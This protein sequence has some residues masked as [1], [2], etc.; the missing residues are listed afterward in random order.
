M[1]DWQSANQE[2]ENVRPENHAHPSVL[3]L[4]WRIYAISGRWAVAVTLATA[5]MKA[6]PDHRAATMYALAVAA[7]G[8]NRLED[9]RAWI[10]RAIDL[11]GDAMKLKALN[12]PK[13]AKIWE[14]K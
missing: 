3:D 13:L 10:G 14:E 12:D 1:G 5:M 8:L 9:A 7:C 4:H 2:L 6:A 11:G